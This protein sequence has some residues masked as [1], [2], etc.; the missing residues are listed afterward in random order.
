MKPVEV[1]I[2]IPVYNIEKYVARCLD[3]VLAQS[4]PHFEVLVVDDGSTDGSA[5][6]VLQ[7]VQRDSRIKLLQKKQWR[8]GK[9][10]K[11]SAATGEW[12]LYFNGGW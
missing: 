4:Y 10:A 11:L 8:P 1:S 2:I 12:R 5:G 7:Y 6:R 9:C 3:S